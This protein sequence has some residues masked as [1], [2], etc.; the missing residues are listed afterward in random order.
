ML[1][2]A[3]SAVAVAATAALVA[4]AHAAPAPIVRELGTPRP[5]WFTAELEQ[6]VRAAGARGV[7]LPAGAERDVPASSLAFTG[8]RPGSWM[9][10]PS[11]CTMNFVF[12][13]S[14]GTTST[15][16]GKG[17]GKKNGGTTTARPAS[18]AP[19][20]PAQQLYIGTAGHCTSTGDEVTV[21]A[22]APNSGNPV[23]VN[24]GTTV[25]SV[26]GGVGNDFALV[27]IRR[28]LNAWVS[29]MMAHWG[30]PTGAYTGTD[31]LPVVHS[32]HGLVIGTGGTPR[33][34]QLLYVESD[35]LYWAGA[36]IF[37]DS[38]SALNVAT[39]L[40]AADITHLVIDTRRPGANSAGTRIT[41]ILQI[42]GRPLAVCAVAVPWPLPGCPTA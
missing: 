21:V 12:I 7:P 20:D 33:A 6:Q 38:G 1:R 22:I 31:L 40:A 36:T 3:L 26:D 14:G 9:L 28:E 5:S 18:T 34:G 39:G 15:K 11:G 25:K 10:A 19:F 30:G 42:A 32:G 17:N 41:K 8:I 2:P 16:P 13:G 4:P 27:E 29:P 37:G 35:A 24:I 23:L